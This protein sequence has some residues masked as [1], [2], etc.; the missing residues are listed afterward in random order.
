[1]KISKTVNG[2]EVVLVPEGI[3][4]TANANDFDTEIANA[5]NMTVALEN[6]EIGGLGIYMVKKIIKSATYRRNGAKNEFSIRNPKT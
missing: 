5:L 4:D 3:I 6:R 2:S 1:M